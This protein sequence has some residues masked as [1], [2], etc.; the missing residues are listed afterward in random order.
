MAHKMGERRGG[1]IGGENGK[2]SACWSVTLLCVNW[3][4]CEDIANRCFCKKAVHL[5]IED[6][7]PV[8][9]GAATLMTFLAGH[10][11]ILPSEGRD[12]LLLY[13]QTLTA[14]K[15]AHSLIGPFGFGRQ[16][17]IAFELAAPTHF[18]SVI[19]LLVLNGA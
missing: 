9:S 1:Y 2:Y 16:H 3:A 5:R 19:G 18:R 10:I 14:R 4:W 15:E 12:K 17:I 8:H 11:E 6:K 7:P 13:L